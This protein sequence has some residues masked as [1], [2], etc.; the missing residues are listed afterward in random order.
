MMANN[1]ALRYLNIAPGDNKTLDF[2]FEYGAF[3]DMIPAQAILNA[4]EENN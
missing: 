2:V 3:L 1:Q 4:I